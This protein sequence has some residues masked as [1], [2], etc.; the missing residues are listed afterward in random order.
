MPM[1]RP[2]GHLA[3]AVAPLALALVP[4]AA[5][6]VPQ[7]LPQLQARVSS[8]DGFNLPTGSSFSSGT[9]DI[10]EQGTVAFRLIGVGF[11]GIGGLWVGANGTGGVVYQA[12]NADPVVTDPGIS[13]GV[14]VFDQYTLAGSQ[15]LRRYS[16]LT[17]QT[18]IAIQPG[19]A[20][21]VTYFGSAQ[22]LDDGRIGFRA[23]VGSSNYAH[24]LHAG[25]VSTVIIGTPAVQ[26]GSPYNFLFTPSFN[27]LGHV[28]SK[29]QRSAGG[30]EIRI[31]RIDGSS[32]LIAS[33]AAAAPGS[34]YTG[35]DN[36]VALT[37]AGAVAFIA[38]LGGGVRGVFVSNGSSTTEI[39]RTQAGQINEIEFFAPTAS[40]TGL[41]AFRGRDGSG[42]RSIFVGDGTQ[43]VR[44][45]GDGSPVP[46]DLGDAKIGRPD[47][48]PVFGGSP[49][50]N[51]RGDLVF[52]CSIMPLNSSSGT[53][54]SAI[55]VLRAKESARPADINGDGTVDGIDL[56]A[57]LAAWGACPTSGSCAADIDGN[58]IVDGL[59]LT[60]LLADWG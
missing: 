34:P 1:Q 5:A 57:L 54:G 14:A 2:L 58:G 12:S 46:S 25:S 29:A 8:F 48:N 53:W 60:A 23:T 31:F 4:S 59:D 21:G 30:N 6:D 37:N 20:V 40:E 43:L 17:G 50:M 7:Y 45:V 41:V 47:T 55:Y 11:T 15:G 38:S 19:G 18:S 49:R 39:A 36:S 24:V 56:T 10:D 42:K 26:P 44:V 27:Q 13:A 16:S 35:F 3:S 52:G 9:P 33:D 32:T 22:V 51:A 28:A